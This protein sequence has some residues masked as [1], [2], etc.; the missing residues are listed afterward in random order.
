MFSRLRMRSLLRPIL[1]C[2]AILGLYSGLVAAGM[3]PSSN[4]INQGQRNVIKVQRYAYQ[5]NTEMKILL[6]GSSLTAN[7][8]AGD[9]GSNVTNMAMAG[10][11]TQTGLDMAKRGQFKPSLVL[12]E[13]NDTIHRKIDADLISSV[14]DPFFYWLRLY[15]PIF[16]EEY[17]PVSI[18]VD[19]LKGGSKKEIKGAKAPRE[20]EERVNPALYKRALERVLQERMEPLSEKEKET[21]RQ[22]AEFIKN[23]V[24]DLKKA[25]VRVVLYDVPGEKEVETTTKQKQV[26]ELLGEL[27]PSDTFEWLASPPAREWRTSDGVHLI[28]SHARDYALFLREQLLNKAS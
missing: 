18:L 5:T 9:I 2:A 6:V 15:F 20:E 10:G 11:S 1:I 27:F 26:R 25:G 3:L 22:E 24:A 4:G 7:I 23:Q 19:S 16:R 21:L 28:R 8:D 12:A 14:Y 17:R 13:I